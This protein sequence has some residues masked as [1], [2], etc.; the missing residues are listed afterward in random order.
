MSQSERLKMLF[1]GGDES[2]LNVNVG[3]NT[4]NEPHEITRK[5]VSEVPK[6]LAKTSS[7]LTPPTQVELSSDSE[8]EDE[9]LAAL[10]SSAKDARRRKDGSLG[11]RNANDS[12]N[13]PTQAS[14]PNFDNT[15]YFCPAI[16][17]SHFPYR[18]LDADAAEKAG[19]AFFDAGKFWNRKWNLYYIYPPSSVSPNPLLLI[20]EPEV[21]Q[22]MKEINKKFG[23]GAKIPEKSHLGVRLPFNNDGTPLP[24]FLGTSTSREI[25][26]SLESTIPPPTGQFQRPKSASGTT[27]RSFA[28]FKDKME[29][30]FGAIRRKSKLSKAKKQRDQAR[31]L[32]LWCRSLKRAQ[33][34]LGLRGRLSQPSRQFGV[35]Y[36]CSWDASTSASLVAAA[37]MTPLNVKNTAPFPFADAPLF[38]SIDIESNEKAHSQILEIGISTLDTLDLEGISPGKNGSNWMGKIKTRHF[39]IIEYRHIVNQ[40]FVAGCPDYFEFGN[41]EW[42]SINDAADIVESFF[43]PP[44]SGSL[45]HTEKRAGT[46][47][48]DS[49]DDEDGGVPL[50]KKFITADNR[51]NSENRFTLISAPV[52]RNVILVGHNLSSDIKYMAQLGCPSFAH[53]ANHFSESGSNES[54]GTSK[55][56]F[57]DSL[58]TNILFRVFNRQMQPSSLSKILVD[59]ELTGWNLH[60]AGN[61]AHYTMQALVGIAVKSRCE[62][63]ENDNRGRTSAAKGTRGGKKSW[64]AEVKRRI[65]TSVQEAEAR[66]R[67]ECELWNSALGYSGT[68]I[69]R[70]D[71]FD[72]GL[73]NG[74]EMNY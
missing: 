51:R 29:A 15:C 27:D 24:Q 38:I 36:T 16:L 73:P 69:I 54:S 21:Q 40:D 44:Y 70:G 50:P 23:C 67:Q 68:W 57:L 39:R 45:K 65:A 53:A 3:L 25:K 46:K 63:H 64:N 22:L 61:D 5:S 58:D 14:Q 26:D 8:Y 6:S 62:E 28:A 56:Q 48:D 7:T 66:I 19:P 71:D 43:C 20:P 33:C 13:K 9:Y 42:I 11:E 18:Y 72:G 2:L 35:D 34:Y 55:A 10:T 30:A 47:T 74:L 1:H 4:Q 41:S 52:R 17:I 37:S 12:S 49:E 32:Q 31:R 60:N 59:L